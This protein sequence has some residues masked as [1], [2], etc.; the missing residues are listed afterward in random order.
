M[1]KDWE[2]EMKGPQEERVRA[3]EESWEKI[4]E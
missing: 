4:D 1:N 3:M 2:R